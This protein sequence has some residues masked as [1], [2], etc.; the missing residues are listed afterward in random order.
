MSVHT[1]VE[2]QNHAAQIRLGYLIEG[3]SASDYEIFSGHEVN[4]INFDTGPPEFNY[5]INTDLAGPHTA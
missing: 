3:V 5:R 2:T 4:F 1:H